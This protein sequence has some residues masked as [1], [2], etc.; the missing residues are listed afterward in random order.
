MLQ[1]LFHIPTWPFQ[2]P[3]L[4][5]WTALVLGWVAIDARTKGWN[6][7]FANWGLPLAMLWGFSTFFLGQLV[8][9]GID[10]S[11][12]EEIV[13]LGIAV[14]GYGLMMLLGIVAGVL[15]AIHRCEPQGI[16]ADEIFSLALHLILFGI[17]GARLFYVIQY[18]D[19][20]SGGTF[21]QRLVAMLDMTKGG[22]VVLGS[23]FGALLGMVYWSWRRGIRFGK[24]ADLVG[25]SFLVGLA[26]GRVGCLLNGCCFG[27]PCE[28]PEIAVRFPPGS[29]PYMRQLSDGGL[30]GIRTVSGDSDGTSEGGASEVGA[31]K[32]KP[33]DDWRRVIEVPT[34]S[35]GGELGLTVDERIL[36]VTARHPKYPQISDDKVLRSAKSGVDM[37]PYV[38][39]LRDGRDRVYIPWA[40]LPA[41]A[42]P[43]H[44]TQVYS[45]VNALLLAGLILLSYRFRR[46]DGQSF[47]LM[48]ILYGITRFVIESI[49]QDEPG[50][51]GTDLT[52]SQWGCLGL[53]VVGSL[54][55]A[56]GLYRGS[57]LPN[58]VVR[59]KSVETA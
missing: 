26:F 1:T 40:S 44:P 58:G 49:R 34:G 18:W 10:P 47:A 30:L 15:L 25:P 59:P 8:D 31:S 38:V 33:S 45:S 4:W 22:L 28:I 16:T 5:V 36:I 41:A 19:N 56:W 23:L 20:F 51:F 6:Q 55:L 7:S 52:I 13:P 24:L 14:R 57:I 42:N 48:L 39:V 54:S 27:G 12:P 11:N 21:P 43:I 32:P 37:P 17:V 3:W 50:Q 35:L 29:A 46:F 53:L 2:L 9:Y